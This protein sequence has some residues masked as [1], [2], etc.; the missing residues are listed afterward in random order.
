MGK[1]LSA[2]EGVGVAEEYLE[3]GRPITGLL[4]DGVNGTPSVVGTLTLDRV[5]GVV[6]ETPFVREG[7]NGQFAYVD[8]WINKGGLPANLTLEAVG[9][10]IGLYKTQVIE[11]TVGGTIETARIGIKEA[12][13]GVRETDHARALVVKEARSQIDGLQEWSQFRAASSRSDFDERTLVRRL[14]ITVE[15]VDEFVWQQGGATMRISNDWRS[16]DGTDGL[17]FDE[18]V[19]L[20]STF[21]EAHPFADHYK[22]QRKVVALLTLMLGVAI[23]FRRH[24][25]KDDRFATEVMGRSV[26]GFHELISS[27]TVADYSLPKPDAA[28]MRNWGVAYLKQLE[29]AALVRWADSYEAWRRVIDP[30]VGVLSRSGVFLEDVVISTNLSLEAAGHILPSATGEEVTYRGKKPTSATYIF[31]CL[32][33]LGLDWSRVAATPIGLARAVANNYNTIKH[34][35]RGSMPPARETH[36]VG[37]VSLIVVRFLALMLLDPTGAR[38]READYAR[39]EVFEWFRQSR[40]R[41]D[42]TGAFVSMM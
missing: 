22:E 32:S 14:V 2:G 30:T 7:V 24:E 17:E 13:L 28:R 29:P 37:Q 23:R 31:R 25:V 27:R 39:G 11:R 3:V 9:K 19:V 40:L 36:L 1:S 10:V 21:Q 34:F 15:A 38:V 4:V 42:D 12:V 33:S 26:S 16:T 20:T 35:D 5:R 6:V 18:S 8:E 41:I